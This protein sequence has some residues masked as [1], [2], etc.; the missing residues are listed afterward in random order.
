M[1]FRDTSVSSLRRT[2]RYIQPQGLTTGLA[3]KFHVVSTLFGSFILSLAMQCVSMDPAI[4]PPIPPN[5]FDF[6]LL[7]G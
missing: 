1:R 7:E 4:N 6:T 3:P 2:T 5:P